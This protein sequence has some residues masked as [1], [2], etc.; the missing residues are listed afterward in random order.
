MTE[1]PKKTW[2][3]ETAAA[4]LAYYF[5]ML[6]LGVW[7]PGAAEAAEAVKIP[8]FTF[9]GGAFALHAGAVQFRQ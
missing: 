2:K 6:T 8:T 9:A 7:Y 1:A 5:L 3:R 4:M